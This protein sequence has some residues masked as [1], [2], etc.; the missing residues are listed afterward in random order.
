MYLQNTFFVQQNNYK[1]FDRILK[2]QFFF[3]FEHN[4]TSN[5]WLNIPYFNKLLFMMEI[6]IKFEMLDVN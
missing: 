3:K 4:F 5:V 2:N 6:I 1:Q